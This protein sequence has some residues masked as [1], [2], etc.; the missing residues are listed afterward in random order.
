MILPGMMVCSS[1]LISVCMFIVTKALRI[2]S[3]TVSVGAGGSIWLNPFATV[4]FNVCSVI[5]VEWCILYPCC[6]GVFGMLAVKQGR[7]LFSSV[8]AITEMKDMGMYEVP[9]FKSLLGF[10]IGTMLANFHMCGIM[11]LLSAVLNILVR[12]SSPRGPMCSRC[13]MLSL[14]RSCELLI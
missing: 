7:R 11:L 4:L 13:L 2:S 6:M 10:G 5:P 14:S 8:F 3:V 12:N 1:F 9:L